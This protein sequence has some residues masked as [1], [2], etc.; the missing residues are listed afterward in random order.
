MK[1]I[2]ILAI[3]F[4]VLMLTSLLIG[5]RIEKLSLRS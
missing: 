3:V 5:L 4:T 1:Q 2:R